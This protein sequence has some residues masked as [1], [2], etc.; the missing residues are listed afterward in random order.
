MG[1]VD[2]APRPEK[3]REGIGTMDTL[4]EEVISHTRNNASNFRDEK[5]GRPG[6]SQKD[7]REETMDQANQQWIS[8]DTHCH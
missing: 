5:R 4:R 2:D 1:A 3:K 8:D 7:A 6:G